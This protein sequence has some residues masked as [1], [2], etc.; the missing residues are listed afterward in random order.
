[1]DRMIA[2]G[3]MCVA[4]NHRNLLGSSTLALTR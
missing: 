1:V 3:V 4:M 2:A